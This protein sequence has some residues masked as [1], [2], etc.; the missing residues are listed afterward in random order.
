MSPL[1][2]R[3]RRAAA[4]SVFPPD[5]LRSGQAAFGQMWLSRRGQL[6]AYIAHSAGLSGASEAD[7]RDVGHPGWGAWD[8]DLGGSPTAADLVRQ[9]CSARMVASTATP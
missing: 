9:Q 2:E 8:G 4:M 6:R 1:A 5:A 3:R 7:V